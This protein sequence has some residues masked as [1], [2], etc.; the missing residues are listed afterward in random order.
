ML[1]QPPV[2]NDLATDASECLRCFCFGVT[3]TCYSS[4]V[5]AETIS[6]QEN[7][8]SIVAM[9]RETNGTYRDVS[10]LYPPNQDAIKFDYMAKTFSVNS[11]VASMQTPDDVHFFWRLPAPFLG[12]H[13]KSYGNYL[14][15]SIDYREPYSP[16][17]LVIPDVIIKGNGITLYHF[18]KNFEK[19]PD[20]NTELK[21]RFWLG[22][23]HRNDQHAFSEVPPLFEDT[24]REDIMIVLQNVQ[25]ILIKASYDANLLET[26][27]TSIE[28]ESAQISNISDPERSAY[29]EQCSCPEGYMGSSCEQCSP[30]YILHPAGHMGRC[31]L[32]PPTC[33]CNGHSE[34]CDQFSGQCLNCRDHTEGL[35]CEKCERGYYF[36]PD[37]NTNGQ[38]VCTKCPCGE[39]S[40]E[41][42]KS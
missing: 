26:S 38:M 4:S 29:I 8:L 27:I 21:V 39:N 3:E 2:F 24:P 40:G 30:G 16:N 22:E 32:A 7:N 17:P 20:G 6:F 11:E 35:N 41:Q 25:D 31:D 23:W 36:N 42:I 10:Y 37:I 1:C 19:N 15:Y 14:K 33:Q 34:E 5:K 28:L 9:I 13:L 18:E 12:N